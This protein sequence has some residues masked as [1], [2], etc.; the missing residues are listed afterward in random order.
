[1]K[2]V[3]DIVETPERY[4]CFVVFDPASIRVPDADILLIGKD[5]V[6]LYESVIEKVSDQT[7]DIK[8]KII[9]NRLQKIGNMID[10][11]Q[12]YDQV[13]ISRFFDRIW[14]RYAYISHLGESFFD[15]KTFTEFFPDY[16]KKGDDL[17]ADRLDMSRKSIG[18][19]NL[20][21]SDDE[22]SEDTDDDDDDDLDELEEEPSPDKVT[23]DADLEV[24]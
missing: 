10:L 5:V 6:D 3:T 21:D 18:S 20:E 14:R 11:L 7:D 23:D 4:Q 19:S 16:I 24:V 12:V 13:I 17:I 15:L 1:M 22:N 8:M 2:K 9:L